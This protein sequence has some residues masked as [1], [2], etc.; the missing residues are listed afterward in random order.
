MRLPLGLPDKKSKTHEAADS[1]KP[2]KQ[3][4]ATIEVGD[5]V[6]FGEPAKVVEKGCFVVKLEFEDSSTAWINVEEVEVS[7]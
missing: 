6:W 7:K 3:K 5:V 4:A 1:L 2:L